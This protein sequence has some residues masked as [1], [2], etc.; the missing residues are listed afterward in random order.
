MT[1]LETF[2]IPLSITQQALMALKKHAA[3]WPDSTKERVLNSFLRK[4]MICHT[5]RLVNILCSIWTCSLGR[6]PEC[7]L[8]ANESFRIFFVEIE[9]ISQFCMYIEPFAKLPPSQKWVVFKNFWSF[10][11]E[12]ERVYA[13]CEILGHDPEDERFVFLN[14]RI[15]HF[16]INM[17]K[18]EQITELDSC[19]IK[20]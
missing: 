20:K 8:H 15:V 5:F 4:M 16:G 11:Y 17:K 18:L 1:P 13:T 19:K 10:F 2:P 6:F 3:W 9:K 7:R 12:L 14:G